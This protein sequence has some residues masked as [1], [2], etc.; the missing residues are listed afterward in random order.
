MTAFQGNLQPIK[1]DA[2]V[3]QA[4]G[5]HMLTCY[6]H[7]AC[8]VLLGAAAA[9]GMRI[10]R[11][12]PMRNVAPDPLHAFV[13]DPQ[14]W[15]AALY[16]TPVPVGI[17]HSHPHTAPW[18]SSADIRGL[19][20]LGAGFQVYLIGSPGLSGSAPR[21]NGFLIDRQ[22]DSTGKPSY[23]LLHSTLTLC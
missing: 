3:Q 2:S 12:L 1:L 13:P 21:L 6:P 8:G 10:G 5:K 7:E 19:S 15:V 11:Y 18:P 23:R 16:L 4:L 22:P 9:G 14:E 20:S 17:F